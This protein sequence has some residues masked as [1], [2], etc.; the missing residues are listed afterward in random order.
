M[1][2][3]FVEVLVIIF[4]AW[5]LESPME[6][7]SYQESRLA[8]SCGLLLEI[9]MDEFWQWQYMSRRIYETRIHGRMK[10][11]DGTILVRT[12]YRDLYNVHGLDLQT[13]IRSPKMY[14]AYN[15]DKCSVNLPTEHANIIR[16]GTIV[17]EM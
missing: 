6:D 10:N 17:N 13:R 7:N 3:I 14:R 4:G 2:T 1:A 9:A 15:P 8:T 5:Q 12:A 11:W 16:Y